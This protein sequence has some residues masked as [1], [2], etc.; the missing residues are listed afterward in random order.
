[1]RDSPERILLFRKWP[2]KRALDRLIPGTE[3][4]DKVPAPFVRRLEDHA[5]ADSADHHLRLIVREPARFRETHGLTAAVREDLCSLGHDNEVSTAVDTFVN[6]C[7][8]P[9]SRER[10][11][12]LLRPVLRGGDE[13]PV[14]RGVVDDDRVADRGL[15]R[16]EL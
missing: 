10:G 2:R 7:A 6:L 11:P 13:P 8:G 16:I 3:C 12:A 15:R 14:V 5:L 9:L 1:M 4:F